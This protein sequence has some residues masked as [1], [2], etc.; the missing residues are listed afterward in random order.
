MEEKKKRIARANEIY[1]DV[2]EQKG[3]RVCSWEGMSGFDS[4]VDGQTTEADLAEQAREEMA[5]LARTFSKYTI[6]TEK[7]TSVE[8]EK[9]A[10]QVKVKAANKIYKKACTDSGRS[11]CFFKDFN[12]WQDFVDGRIGDAELYNKAVEEIEKMLAEQR[13]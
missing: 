11:L 7:D 8:K 2:A 1:C 4:F 5:Q 3:I 10:R 12:S 13:N 9:D 6:V